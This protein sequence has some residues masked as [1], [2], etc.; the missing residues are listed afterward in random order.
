MHGH[1]RFMSWWQ[2][3]PAG[4]V[5]RLR[6]NF[7]PASVDVYDYLQM[8]WFQSARGGRRRVVYGPYVDYSGSELYILTMTVP[9][10]LAG[11][12]VGV[13]GADL[14]ATAL[15][16]RLVL[17]LRRSADEAVLVSAERRVL[18]TNSPRWVVGTRL[19]GLPTAGAS[20]TTV[21]EVPNGT[22]WLVAVARDGAEVDQVVP[23]A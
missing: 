7:D 14:A 6:L 3:S 12:F 4:G 18:A 17:V 15:E 5:A 8:E 19:P 23:T 22:G 1:E 21:E 2:R 20:F 13:V 16:R 11:G 10:H 9:V